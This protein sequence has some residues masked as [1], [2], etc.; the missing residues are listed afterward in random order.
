MS[1]RGCFVIR[2][3]VVAWLN[4][5]PC[6]QSGEPRTTLLLLCSQPLPIPSGSHPCGVRR[7]RL[8]SLFPAFNLS[9]QQAATPMDQSWPF[10]AQGLARQVHLW[11]PSG[12]GR[13]ANPCVTCGRDAVSRWAFAGQ[14]KT[15]AACD[16]ICAQKHWFQRMGY[17]VIDPPAKEVTDEKA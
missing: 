11:P 14:E 3:M 6:L 5:C 4:G 7:I 1:L 2:P 13:M 9:G 12:G 10:M 16:V 17:Q 15:W 8:G